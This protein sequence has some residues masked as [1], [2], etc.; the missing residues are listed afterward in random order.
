MNNRFAT[1]ILLAALVVICAGSASVAVA[2]D[3][4]QF[5][6]QPPIHILSGPDYSPGPPPGGETPGSIACVYQLVKPTKGCA[7]ATRWSAI[8][9]GSSWW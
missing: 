4:I 6:A 3:P 2:Q 9:S 5:F 7:V 8:L 1:F